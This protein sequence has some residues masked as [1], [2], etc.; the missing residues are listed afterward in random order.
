MR[1]R[2]RILLIAI[3]FVA[4]LASAGTPGTFLGTIV[5]ASAGSA[6]Q[7]WVY[8]QGRNQMVRRVSVTGAKVIYGHDVPAG[9]RDGHPAAALI[10]GAEVRVTAEQDSAGE[11]RASLIEILRLPP[12]RPRPATAKL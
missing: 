3:A 10:E 7:N 12:Q 2:A 1:R 8:V 9:L 5:R 4:A 11:W 6:D